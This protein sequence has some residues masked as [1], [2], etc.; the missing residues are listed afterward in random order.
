MVFFLTCRGI[1]NKK[2]FLVVGIAL[3]IVAIY[4]LLRIVPGDYLQELLEYYFG[5]EWI[6]GVDA[7]LGNPLRYASF[8]T[9]YN[10]LVHCIIVLFIALIF[11]LCGGAMILKKQWQSDKI[12]AI[13]RGALWSLFWIAL[14]IS[15]ALIDGLISFLGP[16]TAILAKLLWYVPLFLL[17][18][19]A[20]ELLFRGI[21][22]PVLLTALRPLSAIL[23][24]ASL[25]GA[26]HFSGIDY[27]GLPILINSSLLGLVMGLISYHYQ[28]FLASFGFHFTNNYLFNRLVSN[29]GS[30]LIVQGFI[31]WY[32]QAIGSLMLVIILGYLM[33]SKA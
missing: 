10:R 20:E 24:T 4:H 9:F 32:L 2:S 21:V 25:F 11:Y 26:V 12:A 3:T 30:I 27:F 17:N 1:M 13:D 23:L 6:E 33:R 31:P 8:T 16:D 7:L 14:V 28:T 22:Q 19:F 15:S 5:T 29:N 18:T